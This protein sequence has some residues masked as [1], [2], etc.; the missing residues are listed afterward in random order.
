MKISS[1]ENLIRELP[2]NLQSFDISESNWK[3]DS[4]KKI[5]K[6]IFDDRASITLNRNDLVQSSNNIGEFIIKTLM[7]GYPTKGRGNNINNI[8]EKENFNNLVRILKGYKDADVTLNELKN[9]IKRIRGLGPSTM[10]KFTNFLNTRMEGKKAVILDLQVIK[11]INNGRFDEFKS[12]VGINERCQLSRYPEYLTIVDD[13]S[14]SLKVDPD[15]I[16]QFM[17][18]FGNRISENQK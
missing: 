9:D 2:Y 3:V 16:E 14:R 13:L 12:L 5:V 18:L 1:F 7:W 15:Q 6:K 17:F 8:L 11:S 10:T 4:Q